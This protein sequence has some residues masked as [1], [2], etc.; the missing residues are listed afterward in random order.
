M[1]IDGD[2]RLGASSG[3]ES[4]VARQRRRIRDRLQ[5]RD[6]RPI[7][8]ALLSACVLLL[9]GLVIWIL[10]IRG[11]PSDVEVERSRFEEAS[12]VYSEDGE[13][14]SRYQ[15]KNRTWVSIDEM[16]P[17]VIEALVAVEDHRFFNHWGIDVRRTISSI[18]QTIGGDAQ[19]GS[20]ITMQ[21]ARNAFPSLADDLTAARK[22]KE[23]IVALK[24]EGRYEKEEILEMY[25][26]TV[27]FMY[28][29][30]GIEAGART[31]FQKP[32]SALDLDEAATLIGMLRGT[33]Y[34]NPVRNP[35]RSHERRNVVLSQMVKHDY[36]DQS[37]YDALRDEETNLRFRRLSRTDNLAPYFS[38]YLRGWLDEWAQ[39]NDFNLYTDGLRIYTTIDSRLQ[40]AADQAVKEIGE[41][42]QAVADVDWSAPTPP[43]V[44]ANASAYRSYR[45]NVT[46]FAYYWQ[47][48]QDALDDFLTG[49]DRFRNLRQQGMD[50][51]AALDSL[52]GNTAVV[53]SVKAIYQQLQAAFVA[54]EPGTGEV[55]AWVGGRDFNVT[56]F[57]NVAQAKRQPGST[58]K[59]FVY[60]AAL[61]QG[62]RAT[63]MVRDR[64]VDFVDPQTGRRW[65]PQNVGSISNDLMTL[66]DGLAYSKNTITAQVTIDVGADRVADLA[67]RMGIE[68]DL[69]PYPS[70]GLG[71]SEVSLYELT[72]AYATIA[73]L[74]QYH[75]PVFVQRIEDQNGRVLAQFGNQ[76]TRR[77]MAPETAYELV[78][79][80]QGVIDHGTGVRMR[81]YGADSRFAGK[82]GTS[83]DGADGWFMLMHPDLVVGAWVGFNLPSI[84]FRNNYWGQGSRTALPIV[85][86]FFQEVRSSD[87]NVFSGSSWTPPPGYSAP[88][89]PDPFRIA[90]DDDRFDSLVD[91]LRAVTDSLL[92]R[93]EV[94]PDPQPQTEDVVEADSLNR[95]ERG[96]E[97]LQ[98]DDSP[99]ETA[100]VPA[101]DEVEGEEQ[102]DDDLSEADRLNRQQR[103]GG[104]EDEEESD[105]DEGNNQ[106]GGW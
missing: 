63:D 28:N 11:L 52:R 53:D 6:T 55:K 65:S 46:P 20:T 13:E 96:L 72:S 12:I 68:S 21:L 2:P 61:E 57:D 14:I 79:M 16:A 95:L 30:F 73:D 5:D 81:S 33:S 36:I 59:P 8:I 64:A 70:L 43:F 51:S 71:T 58:F 19:G 10:I 15:D 105:E 67:H 93:G 89:P 32:A 86:E 1:A 26:N 45:D 35:E 103:S 74:G 44:S 106:R 88:P 82:T 92:A 69:L 4:Y 47:Q 37:T 90:S 78:E 91:S 97:P 62:Y 31:Y 99:E 104:P 38:E 18:F 94:D 34:Y 75:E 50:Q 9:A 49:T 84:T 25:L 56:Q 83:Q 27:P 48:N 85:G 80:M 40:Q 102:S 7:T 23:W 98:T 42:L 22:I 87:S 17:E 3:R 77:A 39:D 101:D 29:A 41:N 76:E 54:I 24:L 66:A 100:D 60:G